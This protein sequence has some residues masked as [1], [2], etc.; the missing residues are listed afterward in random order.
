MSSR[1]SAISRG[2]MLGI[3]SGILSQSGL[4]A[5]VARTPTS[6]LPRFLRNPWV[7]KGVMV[8][9]TG[10]TLA[11]AFIPVLPPRTDPPA[12][13]GRIVSGGLSGW[14]VTRER[15]SSGVPGAVSGAVVAAAATWVAT[16]GR[17]RLV[18]RVP[19]LVIAGAET[20]IA[21]GL[22]RRATDEA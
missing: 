17:A 3:A 1:F 13:G 21:F 7:R 5:V 10:E 20:V 16:N 6:N 12:L 18:K 14:I 11:N 8:A 19:D 4:A 15:G 2:A 22:A 9:A